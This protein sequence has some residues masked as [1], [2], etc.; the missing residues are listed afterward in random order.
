MNNFPEVFRCTKSFENRMRNFGIP[1]KDSQLIG[2]KF[3]ITFSVLFEL[4][5]FFPDNILGYQQYRF[6]ISFLY[7]VF[8]GQ[9]GL[10]PSTTRQR[11]SINY[12]KKVSI[13]F[14]IC[15]KIN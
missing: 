13:L 4:I 9:F 3:F 7:G 10:L 8:P 14:A 2:I 5:H 6:A 11:L 12:L 15:V 1:H